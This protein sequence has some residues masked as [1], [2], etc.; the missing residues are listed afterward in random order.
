[1]RVGFYIDNITFHETK[2][3]K[4][5]IFN[6]PNS[7]KKIILYLTQFFGTI[8]RKIEDINKEK[9][10]FKEFLNFIEFFLKTDD[11][12]FL[13]HN[14]ESEYSNYTRIA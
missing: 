3:D 14:D 8:N 10:S 1:M 12:V 4:E 2:E 7:Y 13:K 9:I 6:K 5:E 11:T